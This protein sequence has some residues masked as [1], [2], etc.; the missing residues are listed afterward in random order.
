MVVKTSLKSWT[1]ISFFYEEGL[2][3]SLPSPI[4]AQKSVWMKL[5]FEILTSSWKKCQSN[6]RKRPSLCVSGYFQLPFSAALQGTELSLRSVLCHWWLVGQGGECRQGLW[7]LV[8]LGRSRVSVCFESC[9]GQAGAGRTHSPWDECCEQLS[10]LD[11]LS[12]LSQVLEVV[13]KTVLS[14]VQEGFVL[15]HDLTPYHTAEVTFLTPDSCHCVT[16]CAFLT[17]S[18][19]FMAAVLP[20]SAS[21]SM[22]R[23]KQL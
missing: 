3:I 9:R 18:M 10:S 6:K 8:P 17:T 11:V 12:H 7:L 14:Q 2:Y 4:L 19:G 15:L 16:C 22:A 21:G 13:S 20:S 5:L 23:S 1:Y